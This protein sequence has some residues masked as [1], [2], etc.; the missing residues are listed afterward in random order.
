MYMVFKLIFIAFVCLIIILAYRKKRAAAGQLLDYYL[1][2][3]TNINVFIGFPLKKPVE[4][5]R[6]T[7]NDVS[8]STVDLGIHGKISTEQVR[9]FLIAYPSGEVLDS[10]LEF[11]PLP[12][13]TFF[14]EPGFSPETP[15]QLDEDQIELG[16]HYAVVKQSPNTWRPHKSSYYSTQIENVSKKEFR[17]LKFAGLIKQGEEY[18]L[19]TVTGDYYSD[20]Q[21]CEWYNTSC[22]GWIKPGE[23]V[24]YRDNHGGQ[25]GIWVYF[26][27]DKDGCNFIIIDE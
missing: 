11:T 15:E 27:E 25:D 12:E 6:V 23:V 3:Y 2:N 8:T 14:L 10:Y 24:I 20:R 1:E 22:N 7:G 9:S 5:I 26:C 4:W 13:N 16:K 18:Y 19:N 21:F 17:V